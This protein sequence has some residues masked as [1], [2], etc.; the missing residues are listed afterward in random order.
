M[1]HMMK[2]FAK[3]VSSHCKNNMEDKYVSQCKRE[4]MVYG[5]GKLH[6]M[7]ESHLDVMD[8][9]QRGAPDLSKFEY[10]WNT[11]RCGHFLW[12]LVFDGV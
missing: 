1:S 9:Y 5:L 6:D 10:C 8:P 4:L 12:K 7:D 11:M 2:I 3:Q